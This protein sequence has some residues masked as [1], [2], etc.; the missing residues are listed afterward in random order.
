[1]SALQARLLAGLLTALLCSDLFYCGLLA[2][3]H[4]QFAACDWAELADRVWRVRGIYM[5]GTL[6]TAPLEI[7]PLKSGYKVRQSAPGVLILQREAPDNLSVWTKWR[8]V[9]C[10]NSECCDHLIQLAC[11]RSNCC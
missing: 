9:Q 1:M 4:H 10:Y 7:S 6:S 8:T 3:R 11:T 2:V 5:V